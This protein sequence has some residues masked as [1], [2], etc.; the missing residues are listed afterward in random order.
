MKIFFQVFLYLNVGI[1]SLFFV[2][3]LFTSIPFFQFPAFAEEPASPPSGNQKNVLPPSGQSGASQPAEAQSDHVARPTPVETETKGAAQPE[4]DAKLTDDTKLPGGESLSVSASSVDVEKKL[5]ENSEKNK[6]VSPGLAVV[7]DENTS[8]LDGEKPVQRQG[9]SVEEPPVPLPPSVPSAKED[10]LL[11]ED[12]ENK[13]DTGTDHIPSENISSDLN[14]LLESARQFQENKKEGVGASIAQD[15]MQINKKVANIYKMLSD[16]NYD[17][18]D[19]RDPFVPFQIQK[20]EEMEEDT[21]QV[22]P[23]YPTGKYKLSEIKLVGIKWN[24]KLGPSKALF[25]T[26]DNVIHPLQKNDRIGIDKGVIY[27]LREDEV[28]ILE[29]RAGVVSKTEK[30][31]VPIIVRL[32]RWMDQDEKQD[33]NP[34]QQP[35]PSEVSR[36]GKGV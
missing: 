27:Q 30:A 31:Y 14:N 18:E 32:H 11:S 21:R 29:P 12:K 25:R 5:P 23:S 1:S 16:Y 9:A 2:I 36:R 24:S 22:I 4:G 20:E 34:Q 19:R 35:Q 28:V 26:P 6:V 15:L 13:S 17:P 3:W 8:S 7:K 10:T 33:L